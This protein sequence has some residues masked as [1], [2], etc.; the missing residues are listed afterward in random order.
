M[1]IGTDQNLDY[2]KILKHKPTEDFFELNI[3]NEMIPTITVPTRVSH[4]SNA[5]IDNIYFKST[6]SK[7]SFGHLGSTSMFD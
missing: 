3:A 5:I 7:F 4:T 2:L 6:Q 1:V